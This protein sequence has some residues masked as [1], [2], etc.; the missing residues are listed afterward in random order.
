[1]TSE[2][3]FEGSLRFIG[4]ADVFQLLG[5]NTVTGLLRLT[6][7]HTPNQG[8]I[9]FQ[10]GNPIHATNGTLQGVEAIYPL[11]GWTDGRFEFI[12][13]K[14]QV[15]KTVSHSRMQI[16][17][18]ALRMLDDGMID[19]VGSPAFEEA[20]AVQAEVSHDGKEESLPV[21]KGPLL[22]Y[23]YVIDE[24]HFKD[25]DQIVKEGGHGRWIWMVLEGIV[26]VTK[27]TEKGP[28]TIAR[29]GEGCF[30]GTFT[31]LLYKEYV[32]SA[33]VIAQ[34]KVQLGVLDTEVLSKEFDS[35]SP[36]FRFLLVSLDERLRKISD[37]ARDFYLGKR[38]NIQMKN[39]KMLIKRGSPHKGLY[40]I[41][42]GE[43]DVVGKSRKGPIPL[44]SLGRNEVF[45]T[46]PFMDFG[47]EPAFASVLASEGLKYKSLEAERLRKE[48]DRLSE[49]FRT[50]AHN[51]ATCIGMTTGLVSHLADLK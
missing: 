9:Y 34:G 6:N 49:T 24:D 3:V 28:L 8:C 20:A 35:L 2:S 43:V 18:D 48:F 50:F 15:S 16:V 36:E 19:K 23:V 30:I 13:Q 39:K 14:V 40:L 45:G 21:I 17:L 26:S 41:R 12:E 7:Q 42:G 32:R 25:G 33:S 4:L 37:K 11:F 44:L 38:P 29:L 51:V 47:H 27:N 46:F 1:M 31:S 22:N 10:E 5:G